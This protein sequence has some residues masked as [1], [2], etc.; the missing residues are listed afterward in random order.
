VDEQLRPAEFALLLFVFAA[1]VYLVASALLVRTLRRLRPRLPRGMSIVRQVLGAWLLALPL[2]VMVWWLLGVLPDGVTDA[3][4]PSAGW[5]PLGAI[6]VL[7]ASV[8][9]ALAFGAMARRARLAAERSP[10]PP[11][12]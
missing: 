4:I 6:V 8:A 11:A 1:P 3:L 9:A 12:G 2:T 10:S 7:P 5:A